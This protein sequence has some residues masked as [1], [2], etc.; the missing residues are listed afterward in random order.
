MVLPNVMSEQ[1]SIPSPEARLAGG[2]ST[3]EST[4]LDNRDVAALYII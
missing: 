4:R 2:Q 3:R 1:E